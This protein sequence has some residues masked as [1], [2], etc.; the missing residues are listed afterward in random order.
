[1]AIFLGSGVNKPQTEFEHLMIRVAESALS[2]AYLIALRRLLKLP[3][4]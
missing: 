1:M 3:K 4:S 2:R